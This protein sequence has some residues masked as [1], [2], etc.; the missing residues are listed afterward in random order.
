MDIAVVS[1]LTVFFVFDPFF[2]EKEIR[3]FEVGLY[4]PCV[5]A[6]FR[7]MVP[8]RDFFYLRGPFEIYMITGVMAF[9]G[10]QLSSLY[11]YF[12]FLPCV[13][14][15]GTNIKGTDSISEWSIPGHAKVLPIPE[16]AMRDDGGLPEAA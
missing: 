5:D 12:S 11:I 13:S 16:K 7:G 10:K 1:F 8:F 2:L 14:V 9:L 15:P 4:L 6:I 3:V